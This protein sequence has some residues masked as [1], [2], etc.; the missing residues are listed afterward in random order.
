MAVG[1]FSRTAGCRPE[2]RLVPV[3]MV[4]NSLSEISPD[5]RAPPTGCL[6]WRD[7]SGLTC[8]GLGSGISAGRVADL[9]LTSREMTISLPAACTGSWRSAPM[10]SPA[11]QIMGQVSREPRWASTV[12][13]LIVTGADASACTGQSKRY[14]TRINLFYFNDLSKQVQTGRQQ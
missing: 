9:G 14:A 10:I 8:W 12:V 7:W 2:R 11:R 4:A 3:V 13:I 5:S 6:I 1:S